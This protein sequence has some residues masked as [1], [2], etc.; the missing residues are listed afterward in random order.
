VDETERQA[1]AADWESAVKTAEDAMELWK[2][3]GGYAAIALS[4]ADIDTITQSLHDLHSDAADHQEHCLTDT[5]ELAKARLEA[6][7][8]QEH[9]SWGSVF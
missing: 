4:S 7:R 6:L 5:A 9:I 1:E 3:S 8:R 2:N